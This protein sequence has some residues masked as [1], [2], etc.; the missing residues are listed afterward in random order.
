MLSRV[1]IRPRSIS[2]SHARLCILHREKWSG[3][4]CSQVRRR[5]SRHR[6][7]KPRSRL[8][9][10]ALARSRPSSTRQDPHGHHCRSHFVQ[11]GLRRSVLQVGAVISVRDRVAG[12]PAIAT[13]WI[14]LGCARRN[15]SVPC[16]LMTR[17][18]VTVLVQRSGSPSRPFQLILNCSSI[19]MTRA[20]CNARSSCLSGLDL[21]ATALCGPRLSHRDQDGSDYCGEELHQPD[22]RADVR[23]QSPAARRRDG[24]QGAHPRD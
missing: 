1:A 22:G 6:A 3:P 8:T 15:D 23:G 19:C 13:G 24:E 10:L 9:L 18:D 4:T 12:L 14:W 7:D 5:L 16:L 20:R 2:A 11:R 17:P 21:A